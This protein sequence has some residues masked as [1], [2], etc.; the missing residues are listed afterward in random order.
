LPSCS[1][2]ITEPSIL[3]VIT[4]ST[5]QALYAL[6]S[7]ANSSAAVVSFE[8]LEHLDA[9]ERLLQELRRVLV[10]EGL[11]VVSS[12]DRAIYTDRLGNRCCLLALARVRAASD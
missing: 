3:W 4:P 5:T 2:S 10:P 7:R 12:P 1:K 8:T 11:L 9:Q 6:Q